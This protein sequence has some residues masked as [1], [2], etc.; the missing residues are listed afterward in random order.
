MYRKMIS[1]AFSVYSGKGKIGWRWTILL[2]GLI[3]YARR[4]RAFGAIS[5]AAGLLAWRW[6][7]DGG[8]PEAT[9]RAELLRLSQS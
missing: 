5:Q 4:Y 2:P 3:I 6:Y 9:L 7:N 8:R 1:L